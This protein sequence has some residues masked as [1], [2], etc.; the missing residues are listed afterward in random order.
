[1]KRLFASL[2]CGLLLAVPSWAARDKG[3]LQVCATVASVTDG[4]C[5]PPMIGT[6]HTGSR[7]VV[8]D[9]T[10]ATNC[11]GGGSVRSVCEWSGSALVASGPG[12]LSFAN[13]E[14][15]N[16]DADGVFDFTNDDSGASTITSSDGDDNAGLVVRAGGTGAL[17]LG[18]SDNNFIAMIT[19]G[20]A[21]QLD[22]DIDIEDVTP[23]INFLDS[24]TTTDRFVGALIVSNCTDGGAGT[25]DCNLTFQ[26]V[27]AGGAIETRLN[28]D[29]DGNIAIG[30]ANNNATTI[31]S[32]GGTVTIDGSV[33]AQVPV[34]SLASGALTLNTIHLATAA[35]QYDIPDGACDAAADIG[36]WVTVV[37]EDAS[38]LISITSLDASNVIFFPGLDLDAG[39]ELDS[40][41]TASNESAHI[42]LV[43][44]AA[45]G[46]Y[47]TST[48]EIS[49][50]AIAWADGGAD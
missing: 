38:T 14:S 4:T 48:S 2:A 9:A 19:D 32:A 13:G 37:L 42:T 23:V 30:S 21:I 41:S 35:A 43:C 25:E 17:T 26:V 27:E 16:N 36:N 50:G 46:W 24:D 8:L 15:I 34:V 22:A 12:V 28:I 45:E 49:G 5:G 6:Q 1:M 10:S 20:S 11:T 44:L 31:Q 33:T 39:D 7:V 18:S 3:S 47:T 40:V 29:A